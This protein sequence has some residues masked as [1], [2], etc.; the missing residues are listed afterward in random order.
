[1][2]AAP[3]HCPPWVSKG[4]VDPD[5]RRAGEEAEARKNTERGAVTSA[6]QV[7]VKTN[8]RIEWAAVLQRDFFHL[9]ASD[10]ALSIDDRQIS[11]LHIQHRLPVRR[12]RSEGKGLARLHQ[13]LDASSED[14]DRLRPLVD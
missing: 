2:D 3:V 12:D 10:Q 13:I 1:P 6:D 11:P 14:A 8:A 5:Y 7:A 9:C 4:E